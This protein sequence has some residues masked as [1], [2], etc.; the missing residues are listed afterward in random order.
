MDLALVIH[1]RKDGLGVFVLSASLNEP[2]PSAANLDLCINNLWRH[3][4]LTEQLILGKHA[5]ARGDGV[6]LYNRQIRSKKSH[7]LWVNG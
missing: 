2:L 5:T 7:L 1:C 4:H 6:S 3:A